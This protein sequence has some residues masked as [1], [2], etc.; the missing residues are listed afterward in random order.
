LANLTFNTF[1]S[2]CIALLIIFQLKSNVVHAQEY[3]KFETYRNELV[4]GLNFNTNGG[5]IGGVMGKY[6]IHNRGN[7]YQYIGLEIVNVKHP[8]EV[9]AIISNTGNIYTPFK[10]NAFLPVR[11]Q[12]GREFLVFEPA[13]EEGIQF[14][15]IVAGGLSLGILKPYM[16]EYDLGN[17]NT[18]LMQFDPDK[19]L[20]IVDKGSIFS[21]LSQSKIVPGI[22]LKAAL[23]AEFGQ[24]TS[25]VSGVEIGFL[26]ETY[27]SKIEMLKAPSFI[28]I[29][30]VSL[31]S[32]TSAYISIFF[33]FR[34]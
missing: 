22:N 27:S 5:L 14:N 2:G 34:N 17:G 30:P 33:G 26:V 28:G 20:D 24:Y 13:E 11:L 18:Q 12:Y 9:S 29:Q 15:L 21:G 8:K 6:S 32:F 23:S 16:I 25:N 4:G 19:N 1:F 31:S 3:Q 10:T 7:T